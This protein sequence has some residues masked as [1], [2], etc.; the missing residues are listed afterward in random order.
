MIV[1]SCIHKRQETFKRCVLRNDLPRLVVYTLEDDLMLLNKLKIANKVYHQNNPLSAKWEAG[2]QALKQ[3]DFDYVIMMGADNFFCDN[4]IPFVESQIKHYDMIG[5][6]DLYFEEDD[7]YYYW[8]GYSNHRKGEPAGCGKVYTKE[9][10]ERLNYQLFSDATDRGLDG[11]SWQ[12]TK[13]LKRKVF[14]LK[15]NNL[16][17][18]DIKD[19]KGITKLNSIENINEVSRD[20][21]NL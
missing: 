5:F 14:S 2:V 1:L 9:A 12:R 19:G 21:L 20:I 8:S 4:F 18:Y 10:L 16:F 7:K 6:S 17:L 15:E 3:I 13:K 11:V